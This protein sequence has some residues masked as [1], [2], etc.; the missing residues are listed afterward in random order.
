MFYVLY[1]YH[2]TYTEKNYRQ[3]KFIKTNYNFIKIFGVL[4]R[5][6]K[7]KKSS[8]NNEFQLLEKL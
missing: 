3:N 7:S 4:G 6:R 8:I 5:G 2:Q 1:Y